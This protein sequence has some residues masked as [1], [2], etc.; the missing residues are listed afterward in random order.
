MIYV[1]NIVKRLGGRAVLDD[2]SYHF[3]Q[4]EHIALVGDNG[5]GKSTL[6]NILCGLDDADEGTLIKPKGLVLGYLP[7]EPSPHPEPTVLAE[8]LEGA[9]RVRAVGKIRDRYLAEMAE[10]Y[11]DELYEAYDKAEAEF[12]ELRGYEVESEAKKYLVGLGFSTSQFDQNPLELSGGWRMRLELA[13]ILVNNPNFLILDEPTNHLDLPSLVW[14]E[15]YLQTF[16]GTLLFVSHDRALLNRLATITL[17]LQQGSLTAYTGNYDQFVAQRDLVNLQTEAQAKGLQQKQ[18]HLQLFVDRFGAKASKAAQAQSRQKQIDKLKEEESA[19]RLPQAQ[20]VISA[21]LKIAAPSGKQVLKMNKATVGYTT[22]I[23]KNLNLSIQR[24]QR[25]AIIGANGVGKS[26]L[27]KTLASSLPLIQGE[28]ELGHN[29]MLGYHAQ[30]HLDSLDSKGTAL[31]NVLRANPELS[32]QN[33]RSLLGQFLLQKDDVFK[34]VSVLSGG[35]KN[36]VSLCC[37]LAQQANFLILDEPT[38]HLDMASADILASTLAEFKGTILFVSHDRAFIDTVATHI[39]VVANATQ[40][41]LFEG[42]L[43][44]YEEVAE[45]SG[46]PN[47][48]KG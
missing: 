26:T 29:V 25:I 48:L 1:Q 24:G 5:A 2:V 18:A 16:E 13:K 15:N 9:I 19:L 14:L 21:N 11:S 6:L 12:Q 17:H 44:D 22:P 41:A 37:L 23:A 7:Q 28:L 38:N 42:K 8:C 10:N 32:E 47:I 40:S 3:P 36:R 45:R 46:F 31:E 4:G 35:E 27:V 39:F 34:K 33:V 43:K 30:N 20:R